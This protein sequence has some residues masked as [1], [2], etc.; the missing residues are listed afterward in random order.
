MPMLV[1]VLIILIEPK[2]TYKTTKYSKNVYAKVN[3][4]T[5]NKH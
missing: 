5:T 1:S 3:T 4:A 2:T